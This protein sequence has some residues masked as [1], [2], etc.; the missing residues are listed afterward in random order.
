MINQLN[1]S[2]R[3]VRRLVMLSVVLIMAVTSGC[4]FRFSY[5]RDLEAQWQLMEIVSP[6]GNVREVTGRYYSFASRVVDLTSSGGAMIGGN[7]VYDKEAKLLTLNFPEKG[8]WLG[9]WGIE[10]ST[11]LTAVFE[12]ETL[13]SHTLVLRK[14]DH[15]ILKFR[16]F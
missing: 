6:D 14:P 2:C 4:S 12:V 13:D 16:K 15:T 1:N 8:S 7:M 3:N 11:P 10:Q 9:M 5:D